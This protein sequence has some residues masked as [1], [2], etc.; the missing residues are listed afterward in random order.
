MN[1][2][3]MHY[4]TT[5][6]DDHDMQAVRAR[7]AQLVPVFDRLPGL[8]F[9]LYGINDRNLVPWN[10]YS[11]IY[12]W[13]N[14]PAM[15]DFLLSDG[16]DNYA[17]AFQRPPVRIWAVSRIVGEFEA[18]RSARFAYRRQ[19]R[20]PR[21]AHAGKTHAQWADRDRKTGEIVRV[22]GIDPQRWELIELTIWADKPTL[23]W[24]ENAQLY[25]LAHVSLPEPAVSGS[26]GFRD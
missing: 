11:S 23:N 1:S 2:L 14:A 8:Q 22:V 7:A 25:A 10:E 3:L 4:E 19:M 24:P 13:Q 26:R 9:K 18:L 15:W 20:I 21:L 12:L 17:Q 6:P 16:F 5:L